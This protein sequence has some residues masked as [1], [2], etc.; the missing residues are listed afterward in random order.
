MYSFGPCAPQYEDGVRVHTNIRD[1]VWYRLV[2]FMEHTLNTESDKCVVSVTRC[3]GLLSYGLRKP[4]HIVYRHQLLACVTKK[5][6]GSEYDITTSPS[7]QIDDFMKH[8]LTSKLPMKVIVS[9]CNTIGLIADM[10]N[11]PSSKIGTSTTTSSHSEVAN[12]VAS[13]TVGMSLQNSDVYDMSAILYLLQGFLSYSTVQIQTVACIALN[14][15]MT[16]C[17]AQSLVPS[18]WDIIGQNILLVLEIIITLLIKDASSSSSTG[19][20]NTDKS[21]SFVDDT[22]K[23]K[24]QLIVLLESILRLLCIERSDSDAIDIS[25]SDTALGNVLDQAGAILLHHGDD[26]VNVLEE[27]NH[28]QQS[29]VPSL[30]S[31][32]AY[33]LVFTYDINSTNTT[34]DK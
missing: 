23:L 1:L 34:N 27:Y 9:H 19:K 16:H 26:L 14:R 24:Y 15:I 7:L 6:L 5:L 8:Q 11:N 33:F 22:L 21:Q 17:L 30:N 12:L 18:S 29:I 2:E 3:I 32:T 28:E 4:E 13:L 10:Y 31:R 25:S 20:K